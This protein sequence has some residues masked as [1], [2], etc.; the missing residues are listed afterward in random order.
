MARLPLQMF[1]L[2]PPDPFTPSRREILKRQVFLE[3]LQ[4]W[5]HL[6]LD[7]PEAYEGRLEQLNRLFDNQLVV[8]VTTRIFAVSP[9]APEEPIERQIG[10]TAV[11]LLGVNWFKRALEQT[12]G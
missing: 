2:A 6:R 5:E 7:E 3:A 10:D 12:P 9:Q 11:T 1:N 4:Q 8:R